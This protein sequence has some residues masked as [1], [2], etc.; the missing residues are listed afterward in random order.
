MAV[1]RSLQLMFLIVYIGYMMIVYVRQSV[2]YAA[3]VIQASEK[4]TDS[5]LGLILSSQQLGYTF[6]KFIGGTL[7]DLLDPGLTF[8]TCLL[9]TG[10]TCAAFTAASSVSLFAVIWFMC[11]MAQ[12]PAWSACAVLIKQNF[13]PDQFATWWSILSTSSNVAGTA[14]PFVSQAIVSGFSW[15]ASLLTA[16]VTSICLGVTSFIYFQSS[17]LRQHKGSGNR[18]GKKLNIQAL[19]DPVL[20]LVCVNYLLVSVIRGASNDWGHMYLI[21]VKGQTL[22]AGSSFI[23]IQEVGGIVGSILT[24]YISDYLVSKGEKTT[25]SRLRII[26]FLS[27]LE[28]LGLYLL[29]FHTSHQSYQVIVNLFGFMVGFGMYGIISLLGVAAM[30]V[31]PENL[32]GTAHSL[33]TLGG[34][35]GRVIAGYPLSVIATWRSWHEG[36]VAVLLASVA[37]IGV[38]IISLRMLQSR[39]EARKKSGHS[40]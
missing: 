35:V 15:R 22:L 23:S 3:P 25:R 33:A 40:A 38:S 5:D 26:V 19:F 6:V 1:N 4:L 14:G 10:F 17:N 31:A 13:P 21:K 20:M 18:S 32:S 16:A 9:L 8:V 34:N 36:F 30:E 37:C 39:D 11:G 2:S 12:G 24:G 29:I 27:V 7:A 28:T